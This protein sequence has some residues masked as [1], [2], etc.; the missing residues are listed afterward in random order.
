MTRHLLNIDERESGTP[1]GIALF[2]LGFRPFFL[3]AGIAAVLLVPLWM[4]AYTGGHIGFEYYTP[5][6]WHGHEM[7]FGYT[8]AVI[9]GFLLTAVRNWTDLPTPGGN[10]LAALVLLWLAGR[11][12]PFAAG[13]LPRGIIA[14]LDVA[15]LP[16][17]A[18]T[19]AIPLLRKRQTHN[20]V[21]LLILSALTLANVLMHLQLLGLARDTA[22][23]GL[24][25]A[26]YLVIVLIAILGG[27][28]IPFFT[29]RAIAGAVSR[30]W[31][32]IEYL[33]LGSLAGLVLLDLL[34]APPLAVIVCA[35]LAA[36]AHGMRL[37]G[38]Y[39]R[40]VWAVPL[41]WVLHAGY[42]WL[43][44]G[45][46]LTALAAAGVANPALAIHAFTA[47]GIGTLTL[48]MMARVSL[49]H[50]GRALRIGPAM[51]ASFVLVNLAAVARVL[52]AGVNPDHYIAWLILAAILWSTAFTVFVIHY[53]GVLIRPRIDGRTG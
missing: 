33:C 38:W 39:Q 7:L 10:A 35:G 28:V 16:V 19:L 49:G 50:T 31:Q 5:L 45:F 42:A 15:F 9:A 2:N 13:L 1:T 51:T 32:A 24:V 53:A 23:T 22:K 43:V 12:A 34:H 21:F 44:A 14:A 3:L 40:Q 52:L 25:L 36:A 37:Y 29:E 11:I 48:G 17:L 18:V 46:I 27:R 6:Y 30:Q 41:L 47:G 4:F 8:V 26:V 20:L